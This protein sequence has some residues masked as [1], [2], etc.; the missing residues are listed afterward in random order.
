MSDEERE[1]YYEQLIKSKSSQ[2]PLTDT[3]RVQGAQEIA[4]ILEESAKYA[5]RSGLSVEEQKKQD[6]E[7]LAQIRAERKSRRKKIE[8]EKGGQ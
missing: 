2:P 6:R 5:A 3:E 8:Q 7:T 4:E 1:K